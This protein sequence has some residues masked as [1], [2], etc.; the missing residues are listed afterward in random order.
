M[1]EISSCKVNSW[2]DSQ[3]S[4]CLLWIPKVHY[5]VRPYSEPDE[6]SPSHISVRQ[7]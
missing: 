5:R 1:D 7:F 2:A 4:P 6:S 3:E